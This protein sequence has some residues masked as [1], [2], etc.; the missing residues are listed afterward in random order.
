MRGTLFAMARII[1]FTNQK[2]GVG[3]T[4]TCVNLSA[5]L[6]E[7]GKKVLVIDVDP[8]G[9]A[10]SGIGMEKTGNTIYD[11]LCENCDISDAVLTSPIKG[12]DIIPT[13]V[14]LAGAEVEL[15]RMPNR[16]RLL[17]KHLE[18]VRGSYDYIC[19]DCPPSLG[20]LTLNAITAADALVIPIQCEYFAL[21][22]V[23]LLINT[24]KLIRKQGLNPNL[25]I[26]GVLLTMYDKRSTL[27]ELVAAEILKFFGNKVFKTRIP[28]NVR[29][30][31]APAHG[32]PITLFDRKCAGAV[33]YENLAKE[34]L[35]R[36]K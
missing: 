10:T 3:K 7:M 5:F 14:E 24:I 13:S 22:G 25:D 8:Q 34:F 1:A 32:K 36:Q 35:A 26:D 9:N 17:K 27:T 15:V 29:L 4:T 20:L 31:E 28:R 2:G 11:V 18:R 30:A 21:E 33:A 16:E 19:I 23:A 12:L 6:V